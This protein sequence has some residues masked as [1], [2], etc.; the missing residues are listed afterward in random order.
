[1][2]S[3]MDGKEGYETTLV[4]YI[5]SGALSR[6]YSIVGVTGGLAHVGLWV[7]AL[8]LNI[9]VVTT[10]TSA[11]Q[12]HF[13]ELAMMSTIFTSVGL[14]LVIVTTLLHAAGI[15]RLAPGGGPA[16]LLASITG[17]VF[18]STALVFLSLTSVDNDPKSYWPNIT[19]ALSTEQTDEHAAVRS[20]LTWLFLVYLVLQEVLK[21]NLAFKIVD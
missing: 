10:A 2:Y 3:G 19:G 17:S 12:G 11:D 16:I 8:V 14:G 7:A 9:M 20:T 21:M 5:V 1:M 18:A 6:K 15:Y 4:P 13:Y